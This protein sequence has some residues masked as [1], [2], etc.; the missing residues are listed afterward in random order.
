MSRSS[1]S[2]RSWTGGGRNRRFSELSLLKEELDVFK[3][4]YMLSGGNK[5]SVVHT[6]S[7]NISTVPHMRKKAHVAMAVI[8]DLDYVAD[9]QIRDYAC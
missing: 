6:F 9:L 3:P 5:N 8:L 2:L 7:E 4:R 1:G